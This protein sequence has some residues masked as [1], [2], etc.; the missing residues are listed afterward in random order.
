[1]AQKIDIAASLDE[2]SAVLITEPTRRWNTATDPED[3]K[4][5]Q[6]GLDIYHKG[7]INGLGEAWYDP[8]QVEKIFGFAKL[9][10]KYRITYDSS[11]ERAF[12]VHTNGGLV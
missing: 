1:M 6:R 3:K 9:E 5:E 7:E 8:S 2:M 4:E 10:D 12:N 11:I